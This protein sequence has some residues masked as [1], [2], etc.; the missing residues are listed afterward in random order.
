MSPVVVYFL[1]PAMT[2]PRAKTDAADAPGSVGTVDDLRQVYLQKALS[3]VPRLLSLQDRNPVSRTYGCFSRSYWLD[4]TIDFPDA[5]AQFAVQCLALL[6][7]HQLP[8]N[9]YYRQTKIRDWAVAG[10]DY[11][12]RIQHADGS[13][14]EFYPY[15]RG[16]VGPT[17]L[18]LYAAL[19]AYRLLKEAMPPTTA[20]RV[21]QAIRRAAY[22]VAA[23]EAEQDHLANHHA[24][25][26]LAVRGAY[27]QLGEK[28]LW[29]G[30]ERL[31]R[32]FLKHHNR[33][34]GWSTEYDGADPGYLSGTISFLAKIYRTHP[35]PELLEV[36]RP[37]V[38]FASYFAYPNGHFGG[39]VGSRQTL[40]FYPHG[41][42]LLSQEIP[43]AGALAQRLLQGLATGALVPPEIMPD[44]YLAWRMAEFLQ[45]YLDA[46]PRAS[47]VPTLPY[48]QPP[49]R[50]WFSE[51]GIYIWR[52]AEL[53]MVANLAKGGVV[54]LFETRGG[55]LLYN[56]CGLLGRLADGRMVSSQWID[57]RYG[58]S[59][60][61]GLLTVQG[62]LQQM[63]SSHNF[64]PLKMALF[65]AALAA[66]GRS[67]TASHLIKGGIRRVLMLGNHRVAIRFRRSIILDSDNPAVVD[68]VKCSG[69]ARV[70]E[71]MFGDEFA[72]RYVPQSRYFQP[73]ELGTRGYSLTPGQLARLNER[74]H[75]TV[76]RRIEPR[77]GRV[78]IEVSGEESVK[79]TTTLIAP[80]EVVAKR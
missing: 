12:A 28:Y 14:D 65:R 41:F 44:R 24:M 31:W 52:S 3:Q 7:A 17:A 26:C 40:H 21:L 6:Y 77:S 42:E 60:S 1:E 36:L 63:A 35:E 74:G 57:Q 53:Y 66:V 61:D 11:W 50:R 72:V 47:A 4:K 38:E 25:A 22:F 58:I 73:Q 20:E 30:F 29:A 51:A 43:L 15:E 59:V 18:T 71:L 75:I 78:N 5:M 33:R 55:R 45:A 79:W 2:R 10:L 69:A 76:A 67:P 56:D 64:T 70:A 37:A 8:G 34:E 49:F 27:D 19:D 46:R 62:C 54:K 39:S 32:G 13:F 68:D 16:W 48:E 23:G 9:V 80:H